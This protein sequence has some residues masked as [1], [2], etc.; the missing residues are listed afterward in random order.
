MNVV[1]PAHLDAH[2]EG[3][4]NFRDLGGLRVGAGMVRHGLVF[5]SGMTHHITE[6]GVETLAKQFGLRTIID[7]RS[8]PEL[9]EDGLPPVAVTGIRHLHTPVFSTLNLSPEVQAERNREMREGR[10]DWAASYQRMVT[11]SPDAFRRIFALF[12]DEANHPLV[13]HCTAGRDRTGVTAA[14]LLSL[15]GVSHEDIAEDYHRTGPI[16]Q[17]H[18]DRFIKPGRRMELTPEQ[19][20][21]LLMTTADAM[22]GFLMWLSLEHGGAEGYL[23]SAGLSE[24]EMANIRDLLVVESKTTQPV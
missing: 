4:V 1:M 6:T 5:R 2:I 9:E 7:L 23:H 10:F 12:A 21:R 18:A 15:L 13:F 17:S 19:M 24:P 8:V 22:R 16:L 20:S 14:L 11:E 3:A